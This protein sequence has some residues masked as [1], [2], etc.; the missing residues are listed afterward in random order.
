VTVHANTVEEIDAA[1][2]S[3]LD[4]AEY[5]VGETSRVVAIA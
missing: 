3:T 2:R 5:Y 4:W 1:D